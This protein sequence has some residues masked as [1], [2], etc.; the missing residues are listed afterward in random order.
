MVSLKGFTLIELMVVVA[1]IGVLAAIAVPAVS[2][3]IREAKTTEG[4]EHLK[5]LSDG[6]VVYYNTEHFSPNDA[7]TRFK[8]RYPASHTAATIPTN[9]AGVGEKMHV[10]DAD[11][12]VNPWRE[13]GFELS[14]AFYYQFTYQSTNGDEQFQSDAN[15]SL[16]DVND[17]HYQITGYA[18]GRI[19]PV[20]QIK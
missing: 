3:Y 12:Q 5:S 11:W 17:S 6:A 7:L 1:I 19:S 10:P 16:Q 18:D 9:A 15:A 14:R 2:S 8:F 4:V 13:L 20:L